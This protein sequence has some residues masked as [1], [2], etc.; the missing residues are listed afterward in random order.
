MTDD[1]VIDEAAEQGF[2]LEQRLCGLDDAWGWCHGEETRW[3]TK[4]ATGAAIWFLRRSKARGGSS[5]PEGLEGWGL[6]VRS[7]SQAARSWAT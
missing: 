1:Q 3:P 6:C 2:E 5:A 7:V 4:N